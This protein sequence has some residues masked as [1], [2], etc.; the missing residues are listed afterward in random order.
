MFASEM[1]LRARFNSRSLFMYEQR[2]LVCHARSYSFPRG[3]WKSVFGSPHRL[4]SM[5]TATALCGLAPASLLRGQAS[6][7]RCPPRDPA[8]RPVKER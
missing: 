3:S 2:E 5:Q 4:R 1:V 8:R 6:V 7:P